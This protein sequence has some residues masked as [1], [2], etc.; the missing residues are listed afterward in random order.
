[1]ATLATIRAAL[2]T[3]LE[4][5]IGSPLRVS[6]TVPEM[7][8]FPAAVI[9]YLGPVEG[10][11]ATLGGNAYDDFGITFA[12]QA[13]DLPNAQEALDA[14]MSHS[15]ASSLQAAIEGGPTLGGAVDFAQLASWEEPGQLVEGDAAVHAARAH[16]HV[17]HT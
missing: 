5:A 3:R 12:V 15:G 9:A 8:V 4:T 17:W 6:P 2:V 14:Y 13:S 7:W 11:Y 1:M 16:V 10:P